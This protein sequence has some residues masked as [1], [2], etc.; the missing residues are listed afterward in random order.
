M[1]K[2]VNHQN[3]QAV[4]IHPQQ[5]IVEE[6]VQDQHPVKNTKNQRIVKGTNHHCVKSTERNEETEKDHQIVTDD[7]QDPVQMKDPEIMMIDITNVTEAT[8]ETGDDTKLFLVTN[9]SIFI[10]NILNYHN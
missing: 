7:A 3:I 5:I 8:K 4:S 1:R 6:V 2:S 10:Q 9:F